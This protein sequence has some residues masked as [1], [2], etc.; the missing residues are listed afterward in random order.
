MK[1][2]TVTS[3]LLGLALS[4][5]WCAA[6]GAAAPPI[7]KMDPYVVTA[8]KPSKGFWNSGPMK[9]LNEATGKKFMT[10]RGGP[11]IDA[12]FYRATYL[13]DHPDEKAIII[14]SSE[15]RYGRV[16]A[17]TVV[18]TQQGKLYLSSMAL[19]NAIPF[20]GFTAADID[21]R[22]KIAKELRSIREAYLLS[23]SDSGV[24]GTQPTDFQAASSA[25]ATSPTGQAVALTAMDPQVFDIMVLQAQ[26]LSG[27][28]MAE[29]EETG[30]YSVLKDQDALAS[31]YAAFDPTLDPREALEVAYTLLHGQ[32]ML[33]V[34][35]ARVVCTIEHDRGKGPPPQ[36]APE[37]VLVFDWDGIHYLYNPNIGTYGYKLPANPI[38][39]TADLV[40]AR[41]DVLESL[42]FIATFR[43]RYP[44][45]TAVLLPA[46]DG[47]HTAVAY[48]LNGVL[49]VYS[50][51]LGKLSLRRRYRLE[52]V[53]ALAG[54]H[55]ALIARQA[56]TGRRAA[57]ANVEKLPGDT[58][59]LQV[60]RAYLAL[61][62][63]GFTCE[64]SR[65]DGRPALT[66]SWPGGSYRYVGA[67][68]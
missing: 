24:A 21:D 35:R 9:W 6:Q 19:G 30:D 29:A 11:L 13:R 8:P 5:A 41:G 43:A 58:P 25:T 12:I 37:D 67:P 22:D 7:V 55:A 40:V 62:G 26:P 52:D 57:T 3:W 20:R 32:T 4:P 50:P 31:E 36:T 2:A 64:M 60:R 65:V 47:L 23:Y 56:A 38:T 49:S 1:R 16:T 51:A 44:R 45:A 27:A 18:F 63:A 33:P 17:A 10:M 15:P 68:G 66:V 34:D 46:A 39:G 59:D 48:Q 28:A 14:V 54:L 53:A 61:T 42:Y